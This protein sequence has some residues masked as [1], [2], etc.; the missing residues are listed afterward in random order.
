M[1]DRDLFSNS[2]SNNEDSQELFSY[3]NNGNESQ[4]ESFDLSDFSSQAEFDRRNQMKSEK[5]AK[6]T[7]KQKLIK[8]FLTIFLVG[9]ISVSIVVGSFIVY[10]FTMVD[11]TMPQDLNNLELNLTTTV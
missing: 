4:S 9:V 3:A 11:S 1:D 6:A 7:R 2:S 10:A 8:A 5:K